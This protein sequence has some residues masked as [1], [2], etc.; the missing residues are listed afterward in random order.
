MWRGTTWTTSLMNGHPARLKNL[1]RMSLEV[2][3]ALLN[4]LVANTSL[5]DSKLLS[6]SEKLLI[7]MLICCQNQSWRNTAEDVQH[8]TSTIHE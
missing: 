1:T 5:K 3:E 6:A 8:P 4:W 7:F 2:F